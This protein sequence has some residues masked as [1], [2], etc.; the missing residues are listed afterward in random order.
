MS[1]INQAIVISMGLGLISAVAFSAFASDTQSMSFVLAEI[2]QFHKDILG[3]KFT[4]ISTDTFGGVVIITVTNYGVRESSILAVLDDTGK[5]LEC[6]TNNANNSDFV[7]PA[8]NIVEITCID[9]GSTKF[10]VV[11]ETRQILEALP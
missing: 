5:K 8:N 3:E 1:Y 9:S 4:I 7:V 6:T 11:T 2:N 10:Y